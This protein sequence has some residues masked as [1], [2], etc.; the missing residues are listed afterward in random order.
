MEDPMGFGSVFSIFSS[1]A[2]TFVDGCPVWRL[3]LL[4]DLFFTFLPDV[5]NPLS[6][7]FFIVQQTWS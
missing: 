5:S 7:S 6:N 3:I 1:A 4:L 2:W